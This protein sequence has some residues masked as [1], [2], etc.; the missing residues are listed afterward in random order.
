MG[1][2]ACSRAS[3]RCA[4]A[5]DTGAHR[6]H[7]N[8]T[9]AVIRIRSGFDPRRSLLQSARRLY[10][11]IKHLP[12]IRWI[13]PARSIASPI[14][15][16]A[17]MPARN[18]TFQRGGGDRQRH[19][20]GARRRPAGR[21]APDGQAQRDQTALRDRPATADGCRR[22]PRS[23]RYGAGRPAPAFADT[24]LYRRVFAIADGRAAASRWRVRRK[25]RHRAGQPITAS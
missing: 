25:C 16:R 22:H 3:T 17:G 20:A 23:T 4:P 19:E 12:V 18:A 1:Q 5:V 10:F 2:S 21:Q 7:P 11:G 13:T 6:F 8:A 15:T 9:C 24:E 14:S